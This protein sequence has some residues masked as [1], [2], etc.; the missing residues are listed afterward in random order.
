MAKGVSGYTHTR[1]QL[2]DYANQHNPN[3]SAYWAN[4]KNQA[5]IASKNR[6]DEKYNWPEP[7]YSYMLDDD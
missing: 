2:N 6:K 4:Q 1:Q 5:H 3:N 7:D